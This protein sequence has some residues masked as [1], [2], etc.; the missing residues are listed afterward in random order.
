MH[1][2]G[3]LAALMLFVSVAR[4]QR[5]G[6]IYYDRG[7]Y[8]EF[9]STHRARGYRVYEADYPGFGG[10]SVGRRLRFKFDPM[11]PPLRRPGLPYPRFERPRF[12]DVSYAPGREEVRRYGPRAFQ[13]RPGIPRGGYAI[14]ESP[15]AL[16]YVKKPLPARY[17]Q[18]HE[19]Y[20]LPLGKQKN[21]DGIDDQRVGLYSPLYKH[22]NQNGSPPIYSPSYPYNPHRVGGNLFYP[23]NFQYGGDFGVYL[24]SGDAKIR[25][26]N[27]GKDGIDEKKAESVAEVKGENFFKEGEVL[28]QQSN[29]RGRYYSEKLDEKKAE[30]QSSYGGGKS[31]KQEGKI[32]QFNCFP[33]F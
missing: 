26:E 14:D 33:R 7:R 19:P 25:S 9:P 8:D 17:I 21:F 23:P 20:R 16:Y 3:V 24:T 28:K 5:L 15:S 1:A 2:R 31:Y 32:F 11:A 4:S 29:D 12:Y 6:D 10:L 30:D 27:N 22:V 13:R 18:R